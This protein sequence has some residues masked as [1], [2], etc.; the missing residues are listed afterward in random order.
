[1]SLSLNCF[2]SLLVN[3]NPHS[4]ITNQNKRRINQIFTDSDLMTQLQVKVLLSYL[5]GIYSTPLEQKYPSS[6]HWKLSFHP[7]P[8]P[9]PGY[10]ENWTQNLHTELWLQTSNPFIEQGTY[11]VSKSQSSPGW[12]SIYNHP[13]LASQSGGI[14]RQIPPCLALFF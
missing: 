5:K 6:R 13:G 7:S 1:M 2:S 4:K 8:T 14:I 11:E 10:T 12:I 9:T 3:F